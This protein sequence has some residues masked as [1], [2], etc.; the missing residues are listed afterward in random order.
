MLLCFYD[1]FE[2]LLDDHNEEVVLDP[3]V[4]VLHAVHLAILL[5]LLEVLNY[6]RWVQNLSILVSQK[7]KHEITGNAQIKLIVEVRIWESTWSF[8]ESA[9]QFEFQFSVCSI[10]ARPIKQARLVLSASGVSRQIIFDV[11]GQIA[12]KAR[13]ALHTH[14][15]DRVIHAQRGPNRDFHRLVHAAV[16]WAG[17]VRASVW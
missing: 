16:V 6:H 3:L 1:E 8:V 9:N 4:E 11:V 7:I 12:C 17:S 10:L 5:R 2:N 13:L 15:I 14:S